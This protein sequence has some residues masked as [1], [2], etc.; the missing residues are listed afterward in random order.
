M[1]L[2]E[3]GP[4]HATKSEGSAL[5]TRIGF[6]TEATHLAAQRT[7]QMRFGGS[8]PPTRGVAPPG[9]VLR[10]T[11]AMPVAG[12]KPDVSATGPAP[13]GPTL[14]A[15]GDLTPC[16]VAFDEV[17]STPTGQSVWRIT[18]GTHLSGGLVGET[19]DIEFQIMEPA[20]NAVINSTGIFA[21][22]LDGLEGGFIFRSVGVQNADGS[23][24]MDFTIVPG[25]AH[26]E[27]AGLAGCYTVVASRDHC[28]PGGTPESCTTLVSYTMMYRRA[29]AC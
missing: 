6:P 11:R 26:G 21:G 17:A 28:Q 23:F 14:V 5:D 3:V 16:H 8:L 25:T 20:G 12:T 24:V 22:S 4:S 18:Y 9:P 29:A 27:L 2:A 15:D 1:G 13:T 10:T 7:L 19:E